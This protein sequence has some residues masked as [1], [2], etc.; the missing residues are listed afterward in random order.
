MRKN[1]FCLWGV[2]AAAL[3]LSAALVT[4][5]NK[6]DSGGGSASGGS[7]GG[8]AKVVTGGK[9]AKET[10]FIYELN[11]AGDG[12]IIN[13]YQKDAAGGDV[14]IPS[15]IEGY[16]VVAVIY[17]SGGSIYSGFNDG[18]DYY[19]RD[20]RRPL[21]AA[22]IKAKGLRPAITSIVFPDSITEIQSDGNTYFFH[23][24]YYLKSIAF[25]KNLKAIPEDF[26]S[27]VSSL[28]AVKWP[29]SLGEIGGVAF[30]STGLTEM[31][32]PEGVKI[33]GQSAFS[34]TALTEVVLPEG[35]KTIGERAFE[36]CENLTSVTIP[37]SIETIEEGAFRDCPVLATVKMP[38]HAIKYPSSDFIGAFKNCP[39]LTSIAVRKAIQDTGYKAEWF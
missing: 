13:G 34:G 5:C 6:K 39:K 2:L 30:T 21:T 22:E 12:V 27:F 31:V 9:E 15:R 32:L 36:D 38:A 7:G 29:E 3:I 25:P 28:T 8:S 37:E 18:Y 19:N 1:V 16:P 26:A 10:D 33:I 14:V 24:N 23:D 17:G 20:L 4:G 11:K 35:L